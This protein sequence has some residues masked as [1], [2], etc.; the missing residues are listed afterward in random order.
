MTQEEKLLQRLDKKSLP[1]HIAIVM[2]G[3][4]R[5]AKAR[6]LPRIFGHRKG[7]ESVREVVQVCGELG[8]QVLTLYAF[9]TE[10]W[11]RPRKEVDA[12][13]NLLRLTLQRE[14][15]E[16][17]RNNVRL[18]AIGRIKE[19]SAPVRNGL[20]IA[21]QKLSRNTGL[22]LNLALNYGGR[23]EIVDAVNSLILS[24]ASPN[25]K[26]RDIERHLSTTGLPDPDLFIR[27]SGEMRLSNFLLWQSAYS[28]IYVTP[29]F[30]PEFRRKQLYEAI[31]NFQQRVRRFG[32]L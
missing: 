21:I 20:S 28:E 18:R 15:K 3:N 25:I 16:L 32:G 8:I 6:G 22:I 1:R 31:L 10:N 13:M 7:T 23:Q 11:L 5:W 9:S 17:N 29:T 12:L 14:T 4:G 24:K 26:E 2:D 19:L 27:T 30:W